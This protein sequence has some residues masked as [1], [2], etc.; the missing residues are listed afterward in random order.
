MIDIQKLREARFLA[1]TH[2]NE[3]DAAIW[4]WFSALVETGKIRWCQSDKGWFVTVNRRH[5]AIE[6]RF[7]DAI[8]AAKTRSESLL[9]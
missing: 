7:D 4:R 8:R 2:A 1:A 3:E 5:V 9:K 6:P